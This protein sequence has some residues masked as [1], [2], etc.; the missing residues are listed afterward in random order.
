MGLQTALAGQLYEAGPGVAVFP[1][2]QLRLT[3]ILDDCHFSGWILDVP[4]FAIFHLADLSLTQ[5]LVPVGD[6]GLVVAVV[7]LF[8]FAHTILRSCIPH[9][10][11]SGGPRNNCGDGIKRHG[12]LDP[13]LT[14]GME[15]THG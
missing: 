10:V 12:I 9:T 11:A 14:R 2:N 5:R 6:V 15:A 3:E 4:V 7:D 1:G 13:F 8:L